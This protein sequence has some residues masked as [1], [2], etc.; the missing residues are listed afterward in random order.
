M[1]EVPYFEFVKSYLSPTG[2]SPF[3]ASAYN[4]FAYLYYLYKP[5]VIWFH[6]IKQCLKG[7]NLSPGCM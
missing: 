1:F 7:D 4:I 6:L 2:N 5:E 3:L